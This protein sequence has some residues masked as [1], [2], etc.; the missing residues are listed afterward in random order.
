MDLPGLY[1]ALR[2][3]VKKVM[4]DKLEEDW[5]P[6]PK[7]DERMAYSMHLIGPVVEFLRADIELE[8]INR[9]NIEYGDDHPEI[10]CLAGKK[11]KVKRKLGSGVFGKVYEINKDLVVKIVDLD[12][13][14]DMFT[15]EVEAGKVAARIGVGPKVVDAFTCTAQRHTHYGLILMEHVKGTTLREWVE[16][17]SGSKKQKMRKDLTAL[18]RKMHSHSLYHNDLWNDQNVMVRPDDKPVIIDFGLATRSPNDS[19][20]TRPGAKEQHQDFRILSALEGRGRNKRFG[21]EM[22][23]LI[24]RTAEQACAQGIVSMG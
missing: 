1:D 10:G 6:P 3:L 11:L 9:A 14:A 2:P 23:Q 5:R 15:R 8:K 20:Y 19:P 18:V 7:M 16:K 17:A 12:Y 21:G 13:E 22:R 24:Y 4:A